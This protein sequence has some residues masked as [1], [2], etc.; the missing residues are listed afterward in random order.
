MNIQKGD[1][2]TTPNGLGEVIDDQ[3]YNGP[4]SILS[5][6]KI[7]IK[8]DKSGE[9]KDFGKEDLTLDTKKPTQKEAIDAIDKIKEQLNQI[10]NIPTREK[11]ELPNHLEY[12]KE[13][14][15]VND[16][17]KQQLGLTNLD[18]VDKTLKAVKETNPTATCWNE[19]ESNLKKLQWWS[20]TK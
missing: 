20:R 15:Q 10:P 13:D 8:L 11:G 14:I 5:G 6:P 3:V 7:K 18:Y 12:L 2:V 19:I 1:R 4:F 16:K 17:L 9:A